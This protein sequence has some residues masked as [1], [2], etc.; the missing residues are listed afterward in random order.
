MTLSQKELQRIKVVENVVA[1]RMTIAQG[2]ELLQLSERQVKRLKARMD[3]DCS[4]WVKHGNRERQPAN[5]VSAEVRDKVVG[6]AKASAAPVAGIGGER[7]RRSPAARQQP[8][9]AR[10]R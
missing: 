4:D 6:L 1:G 5:A 2:A 9:L 7:S 3:P 8:I 10:M